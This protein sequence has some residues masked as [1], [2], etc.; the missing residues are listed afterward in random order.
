MKIDS[1]GRVYDRHH[2]K[3]GDIISAYNTAHKNR[4]ALI[5]ERTKPSNKPKGG[6]RATPPKRERIVTQ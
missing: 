2:T 1:K 4:R 6:Y 5:I 3:F